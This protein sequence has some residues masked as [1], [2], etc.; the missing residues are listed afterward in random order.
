MVMFNLF[1]PNFWHVL[2]YFW[3]WT[4]ASRLIWICTAAKVSVLVCMDE[5]VKTSVIIYQIFL[6]IERPTERDEV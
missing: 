5:N 1:T 4:V 3:I 2:F 6:F